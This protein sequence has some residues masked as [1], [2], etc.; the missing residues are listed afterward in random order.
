MVGMTS[1]APTSSAAPTIDADRFEVSQRFRLMVNQYDVAALDGS[2]PGPVAFVHQKRMKLKEQIQVW[3]DKSKSQLL[4]TIKA[5]KMMEIRSGYDVTAPD[6]SPIGV[7]QKVP[8][9]SILR[10]TWTIHDSSG[11]IATVTETSMAIALLRRGMNM[12]G[13]I[14]FVGPI[15]VMIPIPYG[16]TFTNDAGQVVG[17]HKRVMT[18]RDKYTLDMSADGQRAIDRRLAVSMAVCLDALQAR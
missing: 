14:P 6:G 7:L 12:L 5:R 16:F 2:R 15:L 17:T 3:T 8:G 1:H 9:K 4:C 11:K 18:L 10:S 13:G